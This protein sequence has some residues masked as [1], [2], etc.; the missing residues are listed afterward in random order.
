MPLIVLGDAFH[1][2]WDRRL[3]DKRI[4]R[5][6]RTAESF[7][8]LVEVVITGKKADAIA[9]AAHHVVSQI[10]TGIDQ[11]AAVLIAGRAREVVA[12]NES[13]IDGRK[14]FVLEVAA[15]DIAA[16]DIAFGRDR[17]NQA[18]DV[19]VDLVSAVAADEERGPRNRVC[20]ALGRSGRGIASR[21]RS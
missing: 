15:F 2:S 21:R 11:G 9:S 17:I 19:L 18:L 14:I 16:A 5:G 13:E 4:A 6:L 20:D 1:G 8:L 12:D 3:T 10:A 7:Y